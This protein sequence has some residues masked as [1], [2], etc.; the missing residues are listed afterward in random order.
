MTS[1][2][3]SR[4]SYVLIISFQLPKWWAQKSNKVLRRWTAEVLSRVRSHFYLTA[5]Q[6]S[7]NFIFPVR[8]RIVPDFF[9]LLSNFPKIPPLTIW[10]PRREASCQC[11]AEDPVRIRTIAFDRFSCTFIRSPSAYVVLRWKTRD[12]R[13]MSNVVVQYSHTGVVVAHGRP[14]TRGAPKTFIPFVFTPSHGL[15]Y[16]SRV[17]GMPFS[18]SFQPVSFVR[19]TS[20]FF[21]GFKSQKSNS[22]V[23]NVW[24]RWSGRSRPGTAITVLP[25]NRSS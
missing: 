12:H 2:F 20:A 1:F 15:M 21:V 4:H 3:L 23:L 18:K 16:F 5:K 17:W 8:A 13:L 14:I 9:W 19:R 6:N 25:R 11:L 10:R 22:I 7:F 24:T